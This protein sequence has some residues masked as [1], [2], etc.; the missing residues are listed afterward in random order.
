MP[1][2]S[3][4]TRL[5]AAALA[6]IGV[7]Q[8]I[9]QQV[10]IGRPSPIITIPT[11]I[12]VAAI[13]T[14][15]A[16]IACSVQL[17]RGLTTRWLFLAISIFIFAYAG[18]PNLFMIVTHGD[19]GFALTAFGKAITMGSAVLLFMN[20][21]STDSPAWSYN[22]ARICLGLFLVIG[23]VQH[24]LFAD[25]VKFLVPRWIPFDAFWTYAAGVAL[26]ASGLSLLS[27]IGIK[28]I[29]QLA[30]WMIFAWFIVLHIPRGIAD[31]NP[32]ELTAICESLAFSMVSL[33]LSTLTKE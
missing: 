1:T 32:S 33:T 16:L 14:A 30:G 12:L 17:W 23:G 21:T 24:F 18:L 3:T 11:L 26:I 9:F 28:L 6:G 22:L 2:L 8:I 27:K 20:L 15:I 7:L 4:L 31:P 10:L 19:Y 13:L 25:F 5:F 29:A